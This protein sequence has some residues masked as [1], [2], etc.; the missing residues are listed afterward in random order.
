MIK[1]FSKLGLIVAI[2]ATAGAMAAG[3]AFAGPIEMFL[4]SGGQSTTLLV[5]NTGLPS[6]VS[7]TGT[8]NGWSI[9]AGTGGTSYSPDLN[10]FV[11]MDLGGYTVTCVGVGGCSN[12]PLTIVVSA[13][14]F[15]TPID[16]NQ[17][18]L[19]FSGN[20]HLGQ[21]TT[22]AYYDTADTYFCNADNSPSS[23]SNDC[24]SSNLIGSLTAG[25]GSNGESLTGGPDPIRSY[26]LT[27]SDTFLADAGVDPSYS[28]DTTL[29]QV[30]EPGTLALFGAGLVGCALLVSRRRRAR[31]I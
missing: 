23:F 3:T 16:S 31:H 24:G 20:V 4:T 2:A 19:E 10:S 30:P 21:A 1:R 14:G 13:T 26:S 8:L 9:T 28:M 29:T 12:N 6:S 22:S 15:T 17:F 18:L 7:Y 11:G 25:N 27:L 5:G